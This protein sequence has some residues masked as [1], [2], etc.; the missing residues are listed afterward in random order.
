[1]DGSPSTTPQRLQPGGFLAGQPAAFLHRSPPR[2]PEAQCVQQ[3]P[4]RSPM[5][6]SGLQA[7]SPSAAS[8]SP[9]QGRGRTV[10]FRVC[11]E[12]VEVPATLRR[13]QYSLLATLIGSRT[14]VPI[15]RNAEG[16]IP[17]TS[18]SSAAAF[19]LLAH[20]VT[21]DAAA[22][23]VLEQLGDSVV[24][25]GNPQAALS[26]LRLDAEYFLGSTTNDVDF[27]DFTQS[28]QQFA[29]HRGV[30]PGELLCPSGMTWSMHP[31]FRPNVSKLNQQP[32]VSSAR[33]NA[34][35]TAPR[36]PVPPMPSR[37]Y[38]PIPAALQWHAYGE[39]A[40]PAGASVVL[41]AAESPPRGR[42][43]R[44]ALA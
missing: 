26:A 21:C 22:S 39:D 23:V 30:S 13:C 10:A 12:R 16:E 4:L 8:T 40:S 28:L 38:L 18:A 3:P 20:F 2:S 7:W 19:H 25:G 14:A 44:A 33:T 6:S 35:T 15:R 17:V 1:M 11:G 31:G 29:V 42:Q 36:A 41:P 34:Q 9:Q 27:T 37:V 24:H 5:T 43:L 32:A